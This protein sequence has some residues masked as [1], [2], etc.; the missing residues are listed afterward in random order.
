MAF[1][2]ALFKQKFKCKS[3]PWH[4]DESDHSAYVWGGVSCPFTLYVCVFD[5]LSG[6]FFQVFLQFAREQER[7]ENRDPEED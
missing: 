5:L 2:W 3:F 1:T 4:L 7:E 6:L